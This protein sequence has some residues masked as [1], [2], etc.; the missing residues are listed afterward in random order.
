M[1]PLSPI[2]TRR[3]G[4]AFASATAASPAAHASRSAS[5]ADARS[6]DGMK[7]GR[8]P[9]KE[10]APGDQQLEHHRDAAGNANQREGRRRRQG[11][12]R[13]R[14]HRLARLAHDD[15]V[16]D[17]W[18]HE[19]PVVAQSMQPGR[20]DRMRP[21]SRHTPAPSGEADRPSTRRVSGCDRDP[22]GHPGLVSQ[23]ES[24]EAG[25]R[26]RVQLLLRA[27][28]PTPDGLKFS[29]RPS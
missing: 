8:F 21:A 13:P 28:Y 9:S 17:L 23:L 10:I 15:G 7:R 5:S 14:D 29:K 6:S 25:V 26:D 2:A 3:V 16:R 11:V 27:C 4:R 19:V 24:G 12:V 1:Y 18:R 20:T 22:P